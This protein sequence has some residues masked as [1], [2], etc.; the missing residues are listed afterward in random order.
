MWTAAT[1]A[2]HRRDGLRF[3]SDLADAEW[4]VIEPLLPPLSPV[5]R[6]PEW[7]LREIIN[8]IFYVLRGGIADAAA[9]LPAETDRVWLVRGLA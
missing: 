9:L 5:G 7:P 2:Q 6:P 4:T 8:A 1:R 3:A